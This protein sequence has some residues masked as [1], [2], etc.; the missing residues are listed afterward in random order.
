MLRQGIRLF[1]LPAF[2][3]PFASILSVSPYLE[4]PVMF[5]PQQRLMGMLCQPAYSASKP[6][7]ACLLMNAGV[8]H[9]VGP[10]RLNVKLARALIPENVPSLR[11]DLSGRGDSSPNPNGAGQDVS[12][13]QEALIFLQTTLGI[14]R[15]VVMGI[16][17]GAVNAYQLAQA[18]ER[19]VGL[20][21]FD[22]FVFPTR[23]THWLRRWYR[24]RL[25]SWAEVGKKLLSKAR[26]CLR[27]KTHRSGVPTTQP[28][29]LPGS[30]SPPRA[31]FAAVM[32]ALQQRGVRTSMIYSG[33]FIELH[34]HHDQLASAFG[35]ASFLQNLH[36]EFMPDVDHTATPLAAQHKLIT[37]ICNWVTQSF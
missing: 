3:L 16:C 7:I 30:G 32:T 31:E 37:S 35:K 6:R 33:S 21:M 29:P 1:G 27:L 2:L 15:F 5:G 8:V 34:N 11:L 19:V 26:V 28:A 13:L 17:S 22:G 36:Y 24:W 14:E 9:R 12:D 25:M 10:H 20:L 4:T 18:D 23:K